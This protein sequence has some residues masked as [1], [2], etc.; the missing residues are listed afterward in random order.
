M[1]KKQKPECG[2]ALGR[3]LQQRRHHYCNDQHPS[4]A[5]RLPKPRPPQPSAADLELIQKM[6]EEG[7]RRFWNSSNAWKEDFREIIWST[8]FA[9]QDSK[10]RTLGNGP[11]ICTFLPIDLIIHRII[12]TTTALCLSKKS[13]TVQSYLRLACVCF[14]L[15][16]DSFSCFHFSPPLSHLSLSLS[17]LISFICSNLFFIK[18]IF[19]SFVVVLFSS[20]ISLSLPYFPSF[21]N[22]TSEFLSI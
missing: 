13:I 1:A 12:T 4:S 19:S 16:F 2:T 6:R 20:T 7:R 8:K 22:I 18:M 21:F 5:L 15:L 14:A 17:S 11:V 10:I 9:N 3:K